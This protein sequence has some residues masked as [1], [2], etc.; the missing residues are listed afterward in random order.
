MVDS[1]SYI[2]KLAA[3]GY[4]G[5]KGLDWRLQGCEQWRLRAE[6]PRSNTHNNGT[7]IIYNL[8]SAHWIMCTPQ[9]ITVSKIYYTADR[10]LLC[11]FRHRLEGE[12][13]IINGRSNLQRQP[14]T[15]KLTISFDD[16]LTT[17]FEYPSEISLLEEA[18][19][20]PVDP[21][22]TSPDSANTTP[23]GLAS[24]TPSKIQIGS[25][26]ELGVSRTAPPVQTPPPAPP[27]QSERVEEEYLRPADETETVTWS[28][29]STSDMLF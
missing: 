18:G 2:A 6:Q 16:S 7:M 25:T 4:I 12:A 15:K 13:V 17:T 20:L 3:T 26:F 8:L 21:T 24:Y 29:E 22:L 5:L 23:G 28:A 10:V 9:S 1:G 14:K 19:L 27:A 11:T